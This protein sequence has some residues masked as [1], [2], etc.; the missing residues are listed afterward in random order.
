MKKSIVLLVLF[1]F[2]LQSCTSQIYMQPQ[3]LA[4]VVQTK[5]FVFVAKR[6]NPTNYAVINS[7]NA[8][9]NATATRVLDLD[10]GYGISFKKNEIS[11]V[12][13]YFGRSYQ[14]PINTDQVSFRFVSKDFSMT[15]S[16]GKKNKTVFTI[17]PNDVRT[18]SKI[19]IEIY[20]SGSAMVSIDSND[21][22]PISYDGY[23]EK[24]PTEKK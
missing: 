5:E 15:Q 23:I 1:L 4:N 8:I 14:A 24:L 22:Q 11:V 20:P 21:R 7:I 19:Y 17:V 12:L 18:I 9:P 2:F 13:P 10:N 6:A 3:D 16:S